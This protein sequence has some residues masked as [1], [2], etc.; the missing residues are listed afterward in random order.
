MKERMA[1]DLEHVGAG[2]HL[3]A[4]ERRLEIVDSLEMRM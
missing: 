2:D 1:S 4:R 3:K